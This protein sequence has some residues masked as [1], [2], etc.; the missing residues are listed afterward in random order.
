MAPKSSKQQWSVA[1]LCKERRVFV[2]IYMHCACEC[3]STRRFT[4]WSLEVNY[5]A[6][7]M[8]HTKAQGVSA[9]QWNNYIRI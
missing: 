5:N 1:I 7:R 8:S 3:V 2:L 9:A 4:H 6:S